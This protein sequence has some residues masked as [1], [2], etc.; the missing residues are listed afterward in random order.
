MTKVEATAVKE[1][2]NASAAL[3]R[4]A[5][6]YMTAIDGSWEYDNADTQ[7]ELSLAAEEWDNAQTRLKEASRAVMPF[8]KEA[9]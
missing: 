9:K 8:V 7:Y 3:T 1:L 6:R 4:S 2:L 5:E